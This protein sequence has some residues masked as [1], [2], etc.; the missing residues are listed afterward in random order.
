M[1]ARPF[2]EQLV[3]RLIWPAETADF[4][5]D[6]PYTC[7]PW[8]PLDISISAMDRKITTGFSNQGH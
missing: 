8:L 2:P 5:R 6:N 7:D 3:E 4:C 1:R